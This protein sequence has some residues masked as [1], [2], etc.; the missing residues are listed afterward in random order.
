MW[1]GLG[2]GGVASIIYFKSCNRCRGDMH[3]NPDTYGW[4]M[5]CLQCGSQRD[6]PAGLVP[7]PVL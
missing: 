7:A 6:L 4:F 3:L 2:E 1:E 5:K